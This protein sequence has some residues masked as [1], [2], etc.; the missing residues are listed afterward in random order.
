MAN[1][2]FN[3]FDGEK[4][5]SWALLD[6]SGEKRWRMFPFPC[7][8]EEAANFDPE[9]PLAVDSKGNSLALVLCFLV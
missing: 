3:S 2:I 5:K 9:D 8:S 7:P 6:L 4:L 1:A